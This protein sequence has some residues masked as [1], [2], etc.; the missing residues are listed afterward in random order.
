MYQRVT[1]LIGWHSL[2][3]Q[4]LFSKKKL[5]N[6]AHAAENAASYSAVL[7]TGAVVKAC[8]GVLGNL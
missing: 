8:W 3:Q 5:H 4:M 2:R 1:Q 6:P 7:G